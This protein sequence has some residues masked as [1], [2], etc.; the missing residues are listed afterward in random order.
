L[1]GAALTRSAGDI[2]AT[3][4]S[5]QS[6]PDAERPSVGALRSQLVSQLEAFSKSREAQAAPDADVEDARF[7]LVAWLDEVIATSG[8]RH[9]PEWEREP[10]QVQLFGTRNAGLDFYKRMERLR[11][12]NAAALEVFFTCLALGFQGEFAGREG[13]RA[14]LLR[15]TL[16]RLRRDDVGRAMD[17]AHEKRLMP[18]AYQVDVQL[19]PKGSRL[20]AMLA[21][22]AIG[23]VATWA[24]LLAV[25]WVRASGVPV[26]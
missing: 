24:V 22:G 2:I 1:S 21:A 8:W 6:A 18:A 16:N 7:A 5:F 25:L 11:P 26:P 20:F 9:A 13:D 19:N 12:A 3:M 23:L 14:E 4:V 10:L 15:T 17:V